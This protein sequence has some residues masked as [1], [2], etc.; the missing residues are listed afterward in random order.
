MKI[1]TATGLMDPGYARYLP[2]TYEGNL[3]ELLI[4]IKK[5]LIRYMEQLPAACRREEKMS[6]R[7]PDSLPAEEKRKFGYLEWLKEKL[8][9]NLRAVVVYG[10]SVREDEDY[11]DY[12]NYVVVRDLDEAYK[13]LKGAGITYDIETGQ[14]HWQGHAGKEVTLNLITESAYPYISR[15]N[16]YCDRT[17]NQCKIIHGEVSFYR[18]S[19]GEVME[20]S[21][22]S[23]Y[24]RLKM[25][26]SAAVWISRNPSELVG[27]PAL[28]EFFVKH[29]QFF[30]TVNLNLNHPENDFRVL[31]KEELREELRK[32]GIE[33][34]TC[35]SDPAYIARSMVQAAVD[36][37]R[38][39]AMFLENIPPDFSFFDPEKIPEAVREAMRRVMRRNGHFVVRSRSVV[40][41]A[42]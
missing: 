18:V 34:L 41:I 37:F 9:E 42:G 19:S 31:S 20:R 35:R 24:I 4:E 10:S 27:K 13:V 5:R 38:I 26:R 25:L 8:G 29:A 21:M 6:A 14:V 22:S 15:Y 32:V 17:V 16:Q 3:K 11:H 28:F 7:A 12:D 33:P 40:E 36:A 39:H 23:C 2:Y 1:L 30:M